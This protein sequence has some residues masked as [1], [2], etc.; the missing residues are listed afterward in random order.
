MKINVQV[1]KL[2]PAP[3]SIDQIPTRKNG[4]FVFLTF[5]AHKDQA[6]DTQGHAIPWTSNQLEFVEDILR[7]MDGKHIKL[8]IVVSKGQVRCVPRLV[9]MQLD[10][11]RMIRL[12]QSSC[13]ILL[14]DKSTK[15]DKCI[16]NHYAA[17]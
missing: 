16:L 7:C 9:A 10:G 4:L 8:W 11:R 14:F 2:F 5:S 6:Y 13:D 12:L 17:P 15:W 3:I 1:Q